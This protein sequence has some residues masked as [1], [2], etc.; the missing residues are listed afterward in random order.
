MACD[1]EGRTGRS[2]SLVSRYIHDVSEDI[3]YR[4]L[5]V[6]SMPQILRCHQ[7]L[8]T[9][10]PHLRR[11]IHLFISAHEQVRPGEEGPVE[12]YQWGTQ[13]HYVSAFIFPLSP[14]HFVFADLMSSQGYACNAFFGILT[15]AAP[16]LRT[17]YL[18]SSIAR[19]TV[20]LSVPMPNL[21]EFTLFNG[22]PAVP[23]ISPPSVDFPSLKR[24]RFT[25]F[26]DHSRATFHEILVR[27]PNVTHL[28]FQCQ[29]TADELLGHVAS[30]FGLEGIHQNRPFERFPD[31]FLDKIVEIR[32]ESPNKR[33]GYHAIAY[34][35]M[36]Q[37]IM[38]ME[39]RIKVTTVPTKDR[40]DSD[41]AL[42]DWL[43]DSTR[44]WNFP[45]PH[46]FVE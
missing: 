3:K 29:R 25:G 9:K 2:L 14:S 7:V 6:W 13:I 36:V 11:I 22:F 34:E 21:V 4:S 18:C 24:L 41:Y 38:Q 15:M 43:R 20:L 32:V 39:R 23:T 12:G 27:A 5:A 10:P 35:R 42:L 37:K 16:T 26:T 45:T 33:K 8:L 44:E 19:P 46:K 30:V 40:V 1:D 17:F 28:F 31:E